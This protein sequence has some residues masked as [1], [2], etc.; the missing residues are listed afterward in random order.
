MR[1][2]KGTYDLSS[3]SNN[4]ETP[5][6]TKHFLIVACDEKRAQELYDRH[7]SE[8]LSDRRVVD[9]YILRYQK[10]AP[11]DGEREQMVQF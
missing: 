5:P 7:T 2:F 3:R 4:P 10:P 11:L 6:V 9:A 1:L 8:V